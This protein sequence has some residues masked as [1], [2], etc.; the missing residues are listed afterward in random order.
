MQLL[1]IT[2]KSNDTLTFAA[3]LLSFLIVVVMILFVFVSWDSGVMP[4]IFGAVAILMGFGV[5]KILVGIISPF[6]HELVIESDQ[7]RFGRADLP[8][9]QKVL[10]R[11]GIECFIFDS[12]P[13]PSLCV[14][15][16]KAIAP[17]LAPG[18]VQTVPQ[19]QSVASTIQENWLE[20]PVLSREQFQAVCRSNRRT[21]KGAANG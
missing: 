21:I 10:S 18:I 6:Q 7:L 5:A 16:G 17:D 11:S 19:M 15:T 13:D 20:I 9:S 2:R 8:R 3:L 14:H 4:F 1:R 12:G